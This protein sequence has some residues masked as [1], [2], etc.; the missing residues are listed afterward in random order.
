M[1]IAPGMRRTMPFDIDYPALEEVMNRYDP[2]VET[3]YFLDPQTGDVLMID[4]WA[5]REARKLDS[6]DQTD[7]SVLHLAWHVLWYDGEIVEELSEAEEIAKAKQVEAFLV[8]YVQVPTVDS[9]ERYQDMG[10]FA[11]TVPDPHLRE[12][13]EVALTG[14]GAFRRFRDAIDRYYE[15]RERWFEFSSQ[16][17]RER[18]DAWLRWQGILP[19]KEVVEEAEMPAEADT[20]KTQEMLLLN[21]THPL[22]TEHL[23]QI[24]ALTGQAV[25]QVIDMPVQVEPD[26]PLAD[27][28]VEIADEVGLTPE[29]W[30]T[31]PLLVNPPGYAPAATMLLA[32][33]HGRMGH[34]PALLWIRPVAG[35]TP[36]QFKVAEIVNLQT[37]RD[38]AR[39]RR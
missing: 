29:E 11:A 37:V 9:H 26:Q 12:L 25:T 24:E 19:D 35:S 13:L 36:S 6:P 20:Y 8:R 23:A 18:I 39:S 14:K 38:V 32:E 27:Q 7:D 22:T 3:A 33:F 4:D 34:F 17:S 30:Q 16:R 31:L 28:I 2:L 1:A 15:E 10:D 5:E 21:F